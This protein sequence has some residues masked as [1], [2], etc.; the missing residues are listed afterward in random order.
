M[1]S[2]NPE[3]GEI[4]PKTIPVYSDADFEKNLPAW[5]KLIESGKKTA[6]EVIFTVSSKAT[7]TPE[8]IAIINAT[9]V[10]NTFEAE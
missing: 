7:L 4:A 9:V 3:T 2:I 10:N 6:G 5:R 1:K 8:Q